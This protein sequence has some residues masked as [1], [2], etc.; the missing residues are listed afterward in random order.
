[1][2]RQQVGLRFWQES[3]LIAGTYGAYS[4]VRN[5]FGSAAVDPAVA[6]RNADRVIDLERFVGLYIEEEVQSV[7]IDATAFVQFWNL[8]YGLFHFLVTFAV[9]IWLYMADPTR[10][11]F[12]RRAGLITTSSALVGFAAFP[13]MP[14]RLLGDC[15]PYGAC[16][17]GP[18]YVDTVTEVGGIWSF[19]SSGLEA[20]SN[21]YAA[22]PSLHVGWA[23]WCALAVI[24]RL[25]SWWGR[26]LA[27]AYPALTVFAIVVTANHYW[28]D[29]L[30]GAAIVAFGLFISQSWE[31]LFAGTPSQARPGRSDSGPVD[32]DSTVGPGAA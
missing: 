5:E 28:I 8:F 17:Q 14:P 26:A 23:L 29:A 1:M 21:Q 30:G 13:L 24:P 11:R 27:L 2:A 20:I 12:W 22:M 4:L 25:G 31:R 3:V 10:Y 32:L 18:S 6:A 19:E 16:Q 9:L 7:F 15:G